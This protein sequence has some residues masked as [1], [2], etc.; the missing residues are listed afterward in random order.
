MRLLDIFT[1]R[2]AFEQ[3]MAAEGTVPFSTSSFNDPHIQKALQYIS[4]QSKTP[5]PKLTEIINAKIAKMAEQAKLVPSLYETMMKNMVE[6]EVFNLMWRGIP[7]DS[8]EGGLRRQMGIPG[9]ST[10]V[11]TEPVDI[12]FSD[13]MFMLLV[14]HIKAGHDE[15]FPL[16]GFVDRRPQ[17]NE[18]WVILPS[19]NPAYKK[20]SDITTAAATP[21]GIFLF[22]RTFCQKLL[23]Y[24]SLKGIKGKGD[25]YISNGG[26]IPDQYGYIEFLI[27]HELM[28]F[29]NDDFYY[30]HIIPDANPTIINWVGDFRSNYLLVKSGYNQLP[31]GLYNDKINYDR[32]SEYIQMYDIVAAEM[33]KLNHDQQKKVGEDMDGQG[34]DHGP[35]QGEGQKGEGAGKAKGKTAGDIDKNARRVEEEVSKG[36]DAAKPGEQGEPNDS[37]AGA[38]DGQSTI[39]G[40]ADQT[41]DYTQAV[42]SLNWAQIAKKFVGTATPKTTETYASPHRRNATSAVMVSQSGAGAIKPAEKMSE[43]IDISLMFVVDSSGSMSSAV[44]MAYSN[45]AALLKQPQFKKSDC[46]IAR[47]SAKYD[48]HKANFAKNIAAKVGSIMDKPRK[49]ETTCQAVFNSHMGSSTNFN[50]Q[51]VAEIENAMKNKYN[52]LIFSDSDIFTGIENFKNL[53]ILIAKYPRN[54]FVLFDKLATYQTY[55]ERGGPPTPNISHM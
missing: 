14:R 10:P 7:D 47:F 9:G 4:Q 24:G 15:F 37:K 44:A 33:K 11:G 1:M 53:K 36:D 8:F 52:V 30:Q 50:G 40:T 26:E 17:M 42:P 5:I 20:Y 27:I 32:Q 51:L 39:G 41:I 55:R 23:D 43:H 54:I 18:E 46:I 16:R 21:G 22:D 2:E 35:G 48:L 38:E 6:S 29:S 19:A 28:H 13:R 34:D 49:Y 45:I 12:K 31:M 25:K 3:K